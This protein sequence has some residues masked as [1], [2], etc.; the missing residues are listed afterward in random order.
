MLIND[1]YITL[2]YYLIGHFIMGIHKITERIFCTLYGVPWNP[3]EIYG[4]QTLLAVAFTKYS[5]DKE[6]ILKYK[7][8]II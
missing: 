4:V 1:Q 8:K 5:Q 3:I 7:I 2:R 6:N